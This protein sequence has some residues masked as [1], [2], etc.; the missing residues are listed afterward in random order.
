M[1]KNEKILHTLIKVI[2]QLIFFV[3]PLALVYIIIIVIIFIIS[4]IING[5]FNLISNVTGWKLHIYI[6]GR[7][8]NIAGFIYFVIFILSGIATVSVRTVKNINDPKNPFGKVEVITYAIVGP[9]IEGFSKIGNLFRKS[10]PLIKIS[11]LHY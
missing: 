11:K 5:I 3:L 4:E 7:A 2:G 10:D 1:R 6:L 8:A 9:I